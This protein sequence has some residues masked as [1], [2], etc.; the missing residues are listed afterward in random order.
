[1]NR[2]QYSAD[3]KIAAQY[4]VNGAIATPWL[5]AEARSYH[6]NQTEDQL[7]KYEHYQLGMLLPLVD[8][9]K[10]LGREERFDLLQS[11]PMNLSRLIM[12]LLIA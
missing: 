9:R 3:G 10:L 11:R 8:L 7:L 12:F 2:I 5:R 1:M 4:A 6:W